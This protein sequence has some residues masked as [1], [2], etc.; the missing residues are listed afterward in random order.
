MAVRTEALWEAGKQAWTALR[1]AVGV[2]KE[3]K[4]TGYGSAGWQTEFVS[5]VWPFLIAEN[6]QM[7]QEVP[8]WAEEVLQVAER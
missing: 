3:M 5:S 4:R 1:T 2:Y 7:T 6:G 8:E